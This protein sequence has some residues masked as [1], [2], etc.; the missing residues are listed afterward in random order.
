MELLIR[1]LKSGLKPLAKRLQCV[2]KWTKWGPIKPFPREYV[3]GV[4][5]WRSLGTTFLYDPNFFLPKVNHFAKN[6][7]HEEK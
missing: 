6:F 5:M 1:S 2:C 3:L 4:R 7:S